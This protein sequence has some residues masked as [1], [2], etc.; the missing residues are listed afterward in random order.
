[1][2]KKLKLCYTTLSQQLLLHFLLLV[3]HLVFFRTCT[4]L[5]RC[6]VVMLA[7]GDLARLEC[8]WLGPAED[9]EDEEGNHVQ[10]SA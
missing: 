8:A 2:L 9:A 5:V 10:S 3:L 4:G 1:M 6:V 7:A